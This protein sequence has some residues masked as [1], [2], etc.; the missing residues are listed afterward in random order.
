MTPTPTPTPT[1]T[2]TSSVGAL[3]IYS[4]QG[5]CYPYTKFRIQGLHASIVLGQTYLIEGGTFSEPICGEVIAYEETGDVYLGT[6]VTF[7]EQDDCNDVDCPSCPPIMSS[8]PIM[9]LSVTCTCISYNVT[10]SYDFPQE[11]YYTD[12]YDNNVSQSVGAFQTIS[13]CACED[14]VVFP[15]G[16]F[17]TA[18]GE[19]PPVSQI[20][21]VS[22]SPTPTISPSPSSGWNLCDEDFCF[23][24]YDPELDLYNGT[25]TVSGSGV[26]NGRRVY[27]GDVLGIIYYDST[28][29]QWCLSDSIGGSCLFGGPTPSTSSCPDL[30]NVV[31]TNGI[32]NTTTSTTSPCD[33]FDF[34]AYFDCDVPNTPSPTPTNSPTPTQTPTPSPSANVCNFTSGD[35]TISTYTTTTTTIP[36]TTTTTTICYNPLLG[37]VTFTLVETIFVCPGDNYQFTSC[38]GE[39][40]YYVE[41]SNSF[42]DVDL[43]TGFTYSMTI[44]G[45]NGCFVFDGATTIS[46]NGVVTDTITLFT[47]CNECENVTPPVSASSTP[48]P[49]PT[50]TVSPTVTPTITLTPTISLTPTITNSPT[51]TPSSSEPVVEYYALVNGTYCCGDLPAITNLL[52]RRVGFP[53]QNGFVYYDG[54]GNC[55]TITSNTPTIAGPGYTD[56]TTNFVDCSSCRNNNLTF[57]LAGYCYD[58]RMLAD[59]GSPFTN[60]LQVQSGLGSATR[61]RS[62]Y[63]YSY[64]FTGQWQTV[65]MYIMDVTTNCLLVSKP[66]SDGCQYWETNSLGIVSIGYPQIGFD[67]VPA[68]GPCCPGSA[69]G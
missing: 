19:C 62:N 13:I 30:W 69:P 39:F 25:Y 52:V 15:S 37:N 48:T 29:Q 17:V 20:P 8:E 1:L 51:P 31:F 24:T 26:Y 66:I 55:F 65:D 56:I 35:I 45:N 10:N 67:C 4:F 61:Y 5:C 33:I 34:V 63:P 9:L 68:G 44:N 40:V 2:P 12:C 64:L 38:D 21:A 47:N 43:I 36:T 6:G 28:T 11:V 23:V 57:F 60:C 18:T 53:I 27:E 41:P 32:C 54:E 42:V 7:L 59:S 58:G 16:V 3:D 14:T 22:P 50:P 46:P 49:T